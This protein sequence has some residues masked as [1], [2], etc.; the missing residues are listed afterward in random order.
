M[1]LILY[2]HDRSAHGKSL[3]V[4]FDR[5]YGL[6]VCVGNV[7]LGCYAQKYN[8]YRVLLYWATYWSAL[9]ILIFSYFLWC[10]LCKYHLQIMAVVS[11]QLSDIFPLSLVWA[12]IAAQRQK[13]LRDAL[14]LQG[15]KG[16]FLK[17]NF[18]HRICETIYQLEIFYDSPRFSEDLF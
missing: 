8:S 12:R 1:F 9:F 14:F 16:R 15:L 11:F 18:C 17:Y 2:L 4:V 13:W 7:N 10:F 5:S 3:Y 6:C